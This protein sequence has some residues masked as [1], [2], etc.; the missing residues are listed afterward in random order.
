MPDVKLE[1]TVPLPLERAF[2]TYVDDM[3]TWWPR[4]GVFPYS[5][6]PKDTF[7]RHI[8]FE[9]RL[10]G[11]YFETF[12]DGGEFTI[13]RISAWDPPKSLSYGWRDP[14][15]P[16]ETLITLDFAEDAE[17]TSV[18]YAQ[19]GFAAAGVPQ[20]IPYYQIGCRQTL[21]AY[22]AHCRALHEL[23]AAGLSWG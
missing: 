1:L 4:R 21:A 6:A 23:D 18:A 11:R 9:A 22:V 3:N 7:P 12:A 16:G 8:R 5:F 17:G 14:A 13:G 15:W 19:D 2:A 10:N 20:L